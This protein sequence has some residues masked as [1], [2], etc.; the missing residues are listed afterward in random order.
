MRLLAVGFSLKLLFS[1]QFG[2]LLALAFAQALRDRRSPWYQRGLVRE[3]LRKIG[4]VLLHD[5]EHGF[6]GEPAMV[7]GK[8]SV[9]VSKLFVGHGNRASCNPRII[10]QLVDFALV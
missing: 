7:L 8:I 2:S 4:V 5:V 1:L 3:P 9:H 6:P 10:P